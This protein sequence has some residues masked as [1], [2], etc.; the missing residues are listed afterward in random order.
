MADKSEVYYEWIRPNICKIVL[1]GPIGVHSLSPQIVSGLQSIFNELE[2]NK[3]CKGYIITSNT[4]KR[5]IKNKKP[6]FSSGLDLKMMKSKQPTILLKYLLSINKLWCQMHQLKKPIIAAVNGDAIAGGCMLA[7]N[8]DYRVS[9]KNIKFH[10]P[11]TKIGLKIQ[12][13]SYYAMYRVI[14]NHH[15]TS[16]FLQTSIPVKGDKAM[17]L[18]LVDEFVSP[19][20]DEIGLINKCVD[21][22]EKQYFNADLKCAVSVRKIGREKTLELLKMQQKGVGGGSPGQYV[23]LKGMKKGKKSKL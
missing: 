4:S 11:E 6:I 15:K 21:V 2:Q 16:W 18:N 12:P 3:K 14:G 9:F 13:S 17:E 8:C 22:M 1:N 23:G 5:K 20:G 10:M 7:C 19:Q